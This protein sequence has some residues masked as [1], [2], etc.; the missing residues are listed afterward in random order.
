MTTVQ[1]HRVIWGLLVGGLLAVV[2]AF[3]LAPPAQPRLPVIHQ[4]HGFTLTNQVGTAV[5]LAD[6]NG[7]VWVANVIF[8]RCPTQCRKL[9]RQMQRVQAELPARAH[10]VS[11][12]ADPSYDS[13]PVLQRY[14]EQYQTDPQRW[15][16]LTGS[17]TEVYR[18]AVEDLKFSVL[19]S[20]DPAPAKLEDLFIHSTS[21][22]VVDRRGRL[23]AVVQ[24]EAPDAEHQ[25]LD[26][27]RRLLTER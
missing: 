27:V 26:A 14:G 17:K 9:S 2:V 18:V 13:A 16:F 1:F 19:E 21:Y 12:T 6:L 20:G 25:I 4:V 10:L 5:S 3:V 22:S 8:S 15:W 11:L 7:K 23:R 24:G